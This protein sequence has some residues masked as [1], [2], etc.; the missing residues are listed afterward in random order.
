M[1]SAD[2]RMRGKQ[3]AD[4]TDFHAAV[5]AAELLVF[6]LVQLYGT[7]LPVHPHEVYNDNTATSGRVDSSNNNKTTT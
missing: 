6:I 7:P 3:T 2:E 5:I 1:V 4:E